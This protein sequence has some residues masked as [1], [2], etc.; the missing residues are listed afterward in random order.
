MNKD[1]DSVRQLRQMANDSA[2]N[3]NLRASLEARADAV[4]TSNV[5]AAIIERGASTANLAAALA[6]PASAPS[7]Q[8]AQVPDPKPAK[9]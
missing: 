2:S 3:A 5:R 8:V 6:K 9:S 4:S 1:R 7:A